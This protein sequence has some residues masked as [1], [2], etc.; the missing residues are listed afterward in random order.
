M[1]ELDLEDVTLTGE[2]APDAVTALWKDDLLRRMELQ[3]LSR[4]ETG[5]LL[6]TVFGGPVSKDCAE[7]LW[8]LS[9]GN[10]LFLVHLVEHGRESGGLAL[11]DGEWRWAGTLSA[12]PSLAE[13]VEQQI[14]EVPDDIQQVVDLV[15]IAEPID[16]PPSDWQWPL[17]ARDRKDGNP[18]RA[19]HRSHRGPH[20]QPYRH[21][22]QST[23]ATSVR[24]P[25]GYPWPRLGGLG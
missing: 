12:S 25:F 24:R 10:V 22:P 16:E 6:Q 19:A 9:R 7:R 8:K 11:V 5:S 17:E 18:R 14:G 15:A 3:P 4:N 2:P 20:A 1:V 23:D 13:L 21:H